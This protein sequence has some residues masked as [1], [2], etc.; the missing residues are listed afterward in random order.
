MPKR[1]TS[2][3]VASLAGVSRTTVSFVLNDRP[4]V[5]IPG[6]TRRRVLD[7]ARELG[8]HP[9]APARQLAGGVSRVLALVMLQSPEQVAGDALL[10]DTLRGL[11]YAAR[12]GGFRVML[13]PLAHDGPWQTYD[14]TLRE[15]HADGMVISGPR[16]DDKAL[17][18]LVRDGFPIV[19]QGSLPDL[20]VASVDIDNVAAA[21]GAVEHLI[22]LGHRRIACI[23]H[24]PVVY[25]AA[26]ARLRGY[27]DALA[28]AGL[29]ASPDLFEEAAFDA[30]SGHAA[31]ARLLARTSFDAVFVASDVVALGAIGALREAGLHVPADVS[32]V[33][34]DDIPLAAYFDPPLTT[35][36]LPA[37]ELG[38]AAGRALVQRI[39]DPAL[40]YR[41]L[42]PTELIVRASTAS[43]RA[44]PTGA[45]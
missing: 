8:Y 23:T 21:R 13:E 22:G 1:P 18:G 11:A 4:D 32:V 5:K 15:Q 17:L 6:D 34:F 29:E 2:A 19:L 43:P 45:G 20:A 36:R 3:D 12:S 25:T 28:A 41:T 33:G 26:H 35:V 10:A 40:R 30:S 16:V 24:A 27:R 37:F 7:A 31:M 42:L 9:H 39:A 14:A 38:Q 44:L